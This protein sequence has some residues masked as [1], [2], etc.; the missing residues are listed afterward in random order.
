[1]TTPVRRVLA[2]SLATA[3]MLALVWLVTSHDQATAQTENTCNDVGFTNLEADSSGPWGSVDFDA[4]EPTL[5]LVVD[6]GWEVRLCIKAGSAQQGDG[7]EI[8][9]WFGEGTYEVAHSTGKDLSH[10]GV[11]FRE[12]PPDDDEETT[13]STTTT[14]TSSSTSTTTVPVDTTTTSTPSSTST[15]PQSSTTTTPGTTTSQVPPAPPTTHGTP[16]PEDT[17]PFTGVAGNLLGG[18]AVLLILTGLSGLAAVS[19][20][21][22]GDE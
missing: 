5:T 16:S 7:P 2:M 8:T 6:E 21:K 22:H 18:L 19:I 9:D 11:A 14:I 13:T 1:M 20:W 15:V 17:L 3:L 12:A 10:Y 4:T